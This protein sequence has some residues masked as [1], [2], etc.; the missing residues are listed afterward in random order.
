[1]ISI[2]LDGAPLE[3]AEG[4]T[5]GSVLR[6]HDPE[7]C[8]AVI[9][10][11]TQ[12]KEKTENVQAATTAG[13]LNIEIF[14]P[15]SI[16]VEDGNFVAGLNLHWEDR[17]SAA[18]GP[19]PREF[20]PDRRARLYERGD[21][22]LGCGG[23]DPKQSYLIFSRLRHSADHGAGADGGVI[24]RVVSGR[25][26]IDRW[27]P[28]DRI[29]GIVPVIAWADT[30]R[31]FTTNDL[32]LVLEDGMQ[33]VSHVE[34]N[35]Q[36]YSQDHIDPA[37]AASVEHLLL[38]TVTGKFRVARAA[39]THIFDDT[40]SPNDVPM[41]LEQPRREG[42]VTVRTKGR[43]RGGV[44]IYTADVPSNQ[45]HTTV[46]QVTHGIELAKLAKEKDIFSIEVKPEMFDLLGLPLPE[47][48]QIARTR[49]IDATVD[50][51]SGGDRIVV[52][53]EPVTSLEVLA[54][55]AVAITTRPISKVIDIELFDSAAPDTC[56]IFRR[57]S[58]LWSHSVGQIPAFFILDD[59]YL[60]KPAIPKGVNIIPENTPVSEV[61]AGSL[62]MTN[63][64][65]KLVGLV[66]VRVSSNSE[67][68]PTSEP[69]E[70]TNIIGRVL[71]L[72]KLKSIRER[73]I[74]HI[75]EVRR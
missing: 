1:M 50:D 25:G 52:G 10:P 59:V 15:G 28:G 18:F 37:A 64:A 57:L 55:G 21:V 47:A 60:F 66:G 23:Y 17:Y 40:W 61:P 70:G 56:R 8:A 67:F 27:K 75:R 65:R 42:T 45:F 6:D 38:A 35:V 34:M 58:G 43:S 54:K 49:N 19:F 71:D 62:A 63:E 2:H 4:S 73:D 69:F 5:L 31:S 46:G 12:E 51:R 33:V 44:Y 39:S 48:E 9:R 14:V 72:D 7:C 16:P 32:D 24:G 68:G 26:I 29:T 13:E 22:I 3:I 41:E 74:V 30:T 11:G 36:G 20:V 53:Q